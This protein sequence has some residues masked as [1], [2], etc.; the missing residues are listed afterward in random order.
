MM[1]KTIQTHFPASNNLNRNIIPFAFFKNKRLSIYVIIFVLFCL[2]EFVAFKG[3][4]AGSRSYN[5]Y[6]SILIIGLFMAEFS[7]N[8]QFHIPLFDGIGLIIFSF[9]VFNIAAMLFSLDVSVSSRDITMLLQLLFY[10]ICAEI[11]YRKKYLLKQ[12]ALLMT[13]LGAIVSFYILLN[14]FYFFWQAGYFTNVSEGMIQYKFLFTNRNVM[15][16]AIL[17]CIQFPFQ[18]SRNAQKMWKIILY[19]TIGMMSLSIIAT[20]SRAGLLLLALTFML[21]IFKKDISSTT[22]VYILLFIFFCFLIMNYLFGSLWYTTVLMRFEMQSIMASE[23]GEYGRLTWWPFILKEC[24]K[25]PFFGIGTGMSLEYLHFYPHNTYLS[26]LLERG[27]FTFI[28]FIL[29]LIYFLW[30]SIKLAS[31]AKP[32]HKY[33]FSALGGVLIVHYIFSLTG[34]FQNSKF[35]WLIFSILMA[36]RVRLILKKI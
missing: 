22:K 15:A 3:V 14:Y 23:L 28:P 29:I 27:L 6:L 26:M 1:E 32:Q 12:F 13:I 18:M 31:L 24:L 11:F 35:I 30:L 17:I 5:F 4:Q 33:L 7:I 9:F 8:R 10:Y 34:D 36:E 20:Q 16:Y 25:Y 19:F 21:F 2:F